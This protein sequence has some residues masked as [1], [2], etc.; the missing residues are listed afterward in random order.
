MWKSA[1][2]FNPGRLHLLK[3]NH[4]THNCVALMAALEEARYR[5]AE[6]GGLFFLLTSSNAI[7]S[8]DL[9]PRDRVAILSDP[10]QTGLQVLTWV[11]IGPLGDPPF[12]PVDYK[13]SHV[14]I[15][16]RADCF[17]IRCGNLRDGLTLGRRPMFGLK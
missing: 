7:K 3:R 14:L 9:V 16:L 8:P 4:P 10:V 5:I 2:R 6:H 15:L 12:E 13:L 17:G 11:S 1:Q